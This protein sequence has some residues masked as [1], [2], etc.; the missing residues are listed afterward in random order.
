VTRRSRRDDAG[1]T[2]ILALVFLVVVSATVI[3]LSSW[4]Q[5]DLNSTRSFEGAQNFQSAANS[6]TQVAIQYVRYNFL[7]ESLN[8]SPP[9]LCW[10]SNGPASLPF[11]SVNVDSWCSTR[12][13]LGTN[14]YRIVTISTCLSSATR[15]ACEQAPLLQAI[16]KVSDTDQSGNWTCSPVPSGVVLPPSNTDTCGQGLT[17]LSWAFGASPPAVSAVTVSG[18]CA[19]GPTISASGTGFGNAVA[20]DAV[21]ASIANRQNNVVY[22][23]SSFNATGTSQVSAVLPSMIAGS[24]YIRVSTSSGSSALVPASAF[25]C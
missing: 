1:A 3:G 12:L 21:S 18:G 7:Q 17:I 6:A 14:E 8:A 15:A 24:Y 4:A 10:A 2:L 23:A 9:T 13:V 5:G 25:S 20:V 19:S 22:P 11:N 16:V